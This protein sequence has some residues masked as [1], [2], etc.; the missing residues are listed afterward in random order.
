L[1]NPTI[2]PRAIARRKLVAEASEFLTY[3]MGEFS[4]K[5]GELTSAEWQNVMLQKMQWINAMAI[6]DEWKK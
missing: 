1:N 6:K 4:D 3:A 5:H 2:T